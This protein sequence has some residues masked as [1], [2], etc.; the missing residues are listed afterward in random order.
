LERGL[1]S[2]WNSANNPRRANM[3]RVWSYATKGGIYEPEGHPDFSY[4]TANKFLLVE[5][6]NWGQDTVFWGSTH[7]TMKDLVNYVKTGPWTDRGWKTVY[8]F[9]LDVDSTTP[10]PTPMF[11]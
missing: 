7:Q 9:D 5:K 6:K 11:S 10:V 1:V 2:N 8:V 3:Q 4:S